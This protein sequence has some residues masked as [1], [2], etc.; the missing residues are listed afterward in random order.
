MNYSQGSLGTG[1]GQHSFWWDLRYNRSCGDKCIFGR[2]NDDLLGFKVIFYF[3][4]PLSAI[5]NRLVRIIKAVI[6]A[7]V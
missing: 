4:E 5:L 3:L 6:F 1:F 2:G 7:N